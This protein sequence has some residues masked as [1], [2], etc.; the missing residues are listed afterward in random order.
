[1][2]NLNDTHSIDA[3]NLNNDEAVSHNPIVNSW[4]LAPPTNGSDSRGLLLLH[5][6]QLVY[7]ATCSPWTLS[8]LSVS[9]P[10]G[11][12]DSPASFWD[13]HK[14]MDGCLPEEESPPIVPE[15]VVRQPPVDLPFPNLP[16]ETPAPQEPLPAQQCLFPSDHSKPTPGKFQELYL[17][18]TP[19]DEPPA[20]T[21]TAATKKRGNFTPK[22]LFPKTKQQKKKTTK[23][24]APPQ[25]LQEAPL[26]TPTIRHPPLIRPPPPQKKQP[27]P[28]VT[29][30]PEPPTPDEIRAKRVAA[31]EDLPTPPLTQ[32]DF[33]TPVDQPTTTLP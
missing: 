32:A 22:A 1:M 24:T 19:K 30:S 7:N 17:L 8:L 6:N 28:R 18:E 11:E 33:R 9:S 15:T 27:P 5:D 13:T 2:A 4:T 31:Q 25:P 14:P 26:S 10:Q 21:T 3:S 20:E 16:I 29:L 23:K 12:A